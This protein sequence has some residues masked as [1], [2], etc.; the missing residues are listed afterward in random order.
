M[1]V[2]KV[3]CICILLMRPAI[4]VGLYK[5]NVLDNTTDYAIVLTLSSSTAII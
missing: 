5:S 2:D 1:S 4:Y 3:F